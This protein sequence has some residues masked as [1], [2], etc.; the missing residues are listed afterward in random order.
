MLV[1]K[2]L[3]VRR[4]DPGHVNRFDDPGGYKGQ[5][6]G[7]AERSKRTVFRD[8]SR[9]QRN[10]RVED[11]IRPEPPPTTA[12]ARCSPLSAAPFTRCSPGPC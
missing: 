6:T 11:G 8:S 4:V 10:L 7:A 2:D 12:Q 9:T 1:P 5:K 3:Q